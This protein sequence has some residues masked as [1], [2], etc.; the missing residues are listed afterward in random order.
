MLTFDEII[1][2]VDSREQRMEIRIP[3]VA[4]DRKPGNR[5]VIIQLAP[6][7]ILVLFVIVIRIP[8]TTVPGGIVCAPKRMTFAL[9]VVRGR[10]RVTQ[11]ADA[12]P[13]LL[14]DG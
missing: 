12:V 3:S 8:R 14:D 10:R 7:I 9:S 2:L 4:R 5:Q 13:G 6:R 1:P 11:T